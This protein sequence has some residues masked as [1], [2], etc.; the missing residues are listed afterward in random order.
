MGYEKMTVAELKELLREANLPVSGKKSDLI[1]RLN[2]SSNSSEEVVEEVIEEVVE[3]VIE[4]VEEDDFD[5]DEDEEFFDEEWDEVHTARQKPVL[6]DETKANL[7]KRAA[8]MKKQPKFR[9]QEWYRYYRLARTGWRKPKGMQSKQRLN[10]K[11]RTPMVRVGYGKIAA[12]RGLHP[13]GFEDVLV[14]QPSD[15]DGLDPERQ[16]IRIGASVGNRKRANIHD[17]ADDLGL[18]VLNRRKIDRKGDLQ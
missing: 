13:S 7:S 2:E 5:E 6:D 11:Y 10:M 12:V 18:R 4:E 14:N 8:Q 16:A 3:E 15:L 1:L 9:R 17:R